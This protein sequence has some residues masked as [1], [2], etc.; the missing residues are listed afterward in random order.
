MRTELYE[1]NKEE[2]KQLMISYRELAITLNNLNWAS[3]YSLKQPNIIY[4]HGIKALYMEFV[5]DI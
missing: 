1:Y 4:L 3:Y 2:F 5:G